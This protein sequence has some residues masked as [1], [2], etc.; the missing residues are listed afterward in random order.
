MRDTQRERFLTRK[1]TAH[2]IAHD[3]V[4]AVLKEA[5]QHGLHP[6]DLLD[7]VLAELAGTS[8]LWSK[9]DHSKGTTK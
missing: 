9:Y 5:P 4:E 6:L 7:L 2:Q 3:A 8:R 1:R